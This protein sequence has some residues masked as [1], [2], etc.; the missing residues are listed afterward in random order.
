MTD[1]HIIRI[2]AFAAA[3]LILM[4]A[5]LGCNSDSESGD[6]SD[7][8]VQESKT[9]E[10][11]SSETLPDESGTETEIKSD[12]E[13]KAETEELAPL[14]ASPVSLT[15]SDGLESVKPEDFVTD[16][17]GSGN[18]T[19]EF[20]EEYNFTYP[21]NFTVIVNLTDEDG[22]TCTVESYAE[23]KV[24]D[25]A[26]PVITVGDDI[27][28]TVGDSVS[29]KSGVS[30][31]DNSGESIKIQ[32]DNSK[33]DLSKAGTY[34]VKYSAKDSAGNV[35]YATKTVHVSAAP[36]HT[37]EEVLALAK[38]IYNNKILKS[39]YVTDVNSKFELAYAIYQWCYNS[40]TFDISGTDRSKGAVQLAYDG[41]TKLKGDCYTYMITA[42]YLFRVAGI[43]TLEVT[44]LRYE[45][46]SNHFWLLV[47]VGDGWYHFDA[48][49]RSTGRGTD[50]FMLTDEELAAFCEKFNVPHYFRFDKDAYPARSS[51]SYFEI[52]DEN[53]EETDVE[54]DA[55]TE[56]DV[57]V[58]AEADVEV[59]AEVDADNIRNLV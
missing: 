33:V 6:D 24:S 22:N 42:E 41:F 11:T 28:V 39:K 10:R 55:E 20:A 14:S 35:A 37:D 7:S 21:H 32:V 43:D 29:Y 48:T 57:E 31:T 13:T 17:R 45:G 58:D 52:P 34:T 38:K 27:Y 19:A 8:L 23:C 25:T 30:A 4:L 40:I 49:S 47:D 44:R 18:V 2:G 16:V 51:V 59:D 26:P 5:F 50:T 56:P 15:I 1:S 54:T 36:I 3:F 9:E 53:D 12:T 46:E